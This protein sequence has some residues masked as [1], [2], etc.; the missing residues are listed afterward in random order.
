M[1]WGKWIGTGLGWA[2]FGPIGAIFGFAAGAIIDANEY[3]HKSIQ[4]T[5]GDFILS[6]LVLIA[7]VLKADKSVKKSE[8]DFV[9][10]TL[11][12]LIG[13]EE[14]QE[15]II[16]LRDILKKE[17]DLQKVCKQIKAHLDYSSRL[18]LIYL[19]IEIAKSDN[20]IQKEERNVIFQIAFLLNIPRHTFESLVVVSNTIVDAYKILEI[21]P[22]A[23]NEEIKKAYRRLAMEHHPDKVSYLGEE[24]QRKAQ[25]KF[26][27]IQE[28]YEIIKK[29]RGIT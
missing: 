6:L 25:E 12:E 13:Y 23:T 16:L 7:A 3:N 14:A 22:D 29:E 9:K 20:A 5:R 15:A 2:L 1:K 17:I 21:S 24:I 28:A 4:T 27:K 26:K 10:R 8:L 19:L 11:I 18:Q